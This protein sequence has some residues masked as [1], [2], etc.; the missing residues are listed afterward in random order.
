MQHADDAV[1]QVLEPAEVVH[2][3]A[4]VLAAERRRH[5]VDREVAAVEVL[6]DRSLLDRRQRTRAV[7]ELRPR[8]GDVHA[9][10][11]V[12]D[13]RRAE[14]VVRDNTAAKR[15]GKSFA[16]RDAVALDRDVD[17]EVGLAHEH[18]PNG[19]ADE[20]DAFEMLAHRLHRLEDGS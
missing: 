16:E 13:D 14:T 12:D 20:V 1:L 17:V 11:V 6:P 9:A 5:R 19:A 8:G 7:V 10:S 15:L 18:V 3:P 4:E 2:E